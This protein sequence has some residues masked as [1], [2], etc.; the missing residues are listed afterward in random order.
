MSEYFVEFYFCALN[1]QITPLYFFKK[2]RPLLKFL[3]NLK[4]TKYIFKVSLLHT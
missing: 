2:V 1:R 3:D 4:Q